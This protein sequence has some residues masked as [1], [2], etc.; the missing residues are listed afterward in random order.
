MHIKCQTYQGPNTRELKN[1][2]KTN[3]DLA[4]ISFYNIIRKLK[5]KNYL[6]N[7][8]NLPS[9]IAGTCAIGFTSEITPKK[10]IRK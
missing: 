7:N 10:G 4:I 9:T 3:K 1:F 2:K 8:L 5:K 6:S